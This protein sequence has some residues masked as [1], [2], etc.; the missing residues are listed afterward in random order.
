MKLPDAVH[1]RAADRKSKEV[2]GRL[3][4]IGAP[5]PIQ[6]NATPT[7]SAPDIKPHIPTPSLQACL[8]VRD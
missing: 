2:N 8:I 1:L 7:P 5:K 4:G 3:L 6:G